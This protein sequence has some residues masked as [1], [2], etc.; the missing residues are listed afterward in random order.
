MP[1]EG[2]VIRE[3]SRQECE[4]M[5]RSHDHGRLA[6]TFHDRVDIEPIHYVYDAGWIVARTGTGTK[7]TVLAHHPWVAFEVDEIQSLYSWRSVVVKGT[8]Y[9]AEPSA[10]AAWDEG[11]TAYRRLVPSAFTAQDVVPSRGVLLRLHID[12]FHG[13][14][15][16]PPSQLP[17]PNDRY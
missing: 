16:S 15:C 17:A 4:A 14:A 13:R 6:F 5:L 9:L 7:L 11:V 8:V 2:P 1:S 10:G 12:E 3:M